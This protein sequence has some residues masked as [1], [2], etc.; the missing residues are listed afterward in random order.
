MTESTHVS[1]CICTFKRPAL[2]QRLLRKLLKQEL[3]GQDKFSIIVADNDETESAREIVESF[4][5]A[6]VSV[7]YCCEPRKNIALARNVALAN[8][9]GSHIAF[10]DDDEFPEP[11]WLANLLE[12][13]R[14]NNADAV[15]GPVKPHFENPP[16]Q[17][18]V[19]GGFFNR[20]EPITG[21]WLPWTNCRTG[22][23]LFSRKLLSKISPPFD[24]RF[25]TG[26]E[27]V[28][29]FRRLSE[30][31][32]RFVWSNEAIVYETVPASRCSRRYLLHRALLR[33]QNSLKVVRGRSKPIL[34]SFV[35]LPIYLVVVPFALL[36]GHHRFMNFCIKSCDHLGR[37]LAWIGLSPIR[38]RQM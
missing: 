12:A 38:E 27:D 17:W 34:K 5:D 7:I 25:G 2:L 23:V 8:S 3:V 10:I 36:V 22:N 33:G 31:G 24:E 19:K 1:V 21:T 26:G 11:D 6:C 14:I 30:S 13:Q 15:L 35:E 4:E 20:P 32:A 29:F 9:S 37:L 18:V 16:S 28:D